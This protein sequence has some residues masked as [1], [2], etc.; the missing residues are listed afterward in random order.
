MLSLTERLTGCVSLMGFAHWQYVPHRHIPLTEHA[1]A[2]HITGGAI[3]L[4]WPE[5]TDSFPAV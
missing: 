3:H 1:F 5:R 2:I 4:T